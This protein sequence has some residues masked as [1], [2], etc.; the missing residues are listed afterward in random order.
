VRLGPNANCAEGI[1]QVSADP[2]LRRSGPRCLPT[3]K[4]MRA[5]S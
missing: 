5:A 3:I 1:P 2:Y 4:R